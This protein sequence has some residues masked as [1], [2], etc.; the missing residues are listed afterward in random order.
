MISMPMMRP[1]LK[2][3]VLKREHAFHMGYK[4]GDKVF[5]VFATKLQ[6]EESLVD[7]YEE[8]WDQHWKVVNDEFEVFLKGD[9]N[10]SRFS[11]HMLHVKDENHHF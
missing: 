5:Y 10:F 9:P 3:D 8:G 1:T 11:G 4:E 7:A 2:I 6:G